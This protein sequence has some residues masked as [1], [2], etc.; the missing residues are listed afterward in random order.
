MD[1]QVADDVARVCERDSGVNIDGPWQVQSCSAPKLLQVFA[2]WLIPSLAAVRTK[3]QPWQPPCC[4]SNGSD[5]DPKET[6]GGGRPE[7]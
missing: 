1:A 6:I 7:R 5:P 3:K 2:A 4:G